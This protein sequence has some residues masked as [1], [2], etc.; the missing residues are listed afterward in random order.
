MP[1]KLRCTGCTKRAN[2][3]FSSFVSLCTSF[4][5]ALSRAVKQKRS[6]GDKTERKKKLKQSCFTF[7]TVLSLF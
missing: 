6:S 3:Q 5:A 1:V 2:W 7:V 4:N